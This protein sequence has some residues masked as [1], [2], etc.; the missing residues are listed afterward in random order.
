MNLEANAKK[1][2]SVGW[3]EP[4][5]RR[6]PKTTIFLIWFCP[7]ELYLHPEDAHG[8][9]ANLEE[10]ALGEDGRC[11]EL[12]R[13]QLTRILGPKFV[14]QPVDIHRIDL[15]ISTRVQET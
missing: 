4:Q 10:L 15:H 6:S 11:L 13:L 12:I 7:W 8:L 5:I 1:S 14:I 9:F 2:V 3:L